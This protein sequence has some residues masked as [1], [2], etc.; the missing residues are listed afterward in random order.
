MHSKGPSANKKAGE[1][2]GEGT[3]NIEMATLFCGN[4]GGI[5]ISISQEQA[6]TGGGSGTHKRLYAC[7]VCGRSFKS[8]QALGGHRSHHVKMEK[9]RSSSVDDDGGVSV[10]V[11]SYSWAIV[12]YVGIAIFD[13]VQSAGEVPGDHEQEEER[14]LVLGIDLNERPPEWIE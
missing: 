2:A 8:Y 4:S 1:T 14:A 6:S 3:E 12:P 7:S 9:I 10:G 13:Q 11:A 5:D